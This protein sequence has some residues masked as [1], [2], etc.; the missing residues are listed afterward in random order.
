MRA[1]IWTVAVVVFL[2]GAW[3]LLLRHPDARARDAEGRC[4]L[5]ARVYTDGEGTANPRRIFGMQDL[6]EADWTDVRIT[7][8]GVGTAGVFA[9]KPTGTFTLELP[10]YNGGVSAHHTR[11]VPLDD[12]ASAAGPRWSSLT[13]RVTHAEIAGRIGAESC[14][15]D[16]PLPQPK[17]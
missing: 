10:T 8:S 14:S 13:M 11:E 7:I 1:L 17:P 9:G 16:T 2:F 3:R 6:D 4:L 12:F 15:I 5:R